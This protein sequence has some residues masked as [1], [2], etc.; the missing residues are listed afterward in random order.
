MKSDILNRQTEKKEV[1]YVKKTIDQLSEGIN[2]RLGG[3]EESKEKLNNFIK[4]HKNI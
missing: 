4:N 1:N 3:N 2:E